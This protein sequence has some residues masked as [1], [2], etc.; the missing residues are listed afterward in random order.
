MNL[1]RRPASHRTSAHRLSAPL[2]VLVLA[3]A[4]PVAAAADDGTPG[5]G[6]KDL[7]PDP[8]AV[9]PPLLQKPIYGCADSVVVKGFAPHAGLR[10][11]VAG[12]MNPI[13]QK[14]GVHTDGEPV[15]V[16]ISFTAGQV[17]TATQI[18]GGVESPHS[19]A[20]TVKNY[21][22]DY[23]SG[24]P[25]PRIDPATCLDCGKAVGVNDVIP[26][27]WWKVYAE[28]PKQGGGFDPPVQIGG[29]QDFPY[30]FVPGF[31]TGQ[32]ITVRS[33]IC[34]DT[35]PLSDPQI[36][37]ADPGSIPAPVIDTVYEGADRVVVRGPGGTALLDGA[38]LTVYGNLVPPPGDV[39]GGQAT[40]GGAQQVLITPNAPAG[41]HKY[42][43]AQAL[44]SSS[45]PGP[46]TPEQPC[47]K[48]P[49]ATI[50]SPL[51]GDT[52]VEVT[53]FVPGSVIRIYDGIKQIGL[54][55]GPEI[56][57]LQPI[58]NGDKIT[59]VQS[60]GACQGDATYVAQAG[61]GDR[62]P[63]ACSA[64]WPTFRHS[65][66]RDG[67]QP[68]ASAIADPDKVRH[69]KVKWK[70]SPPPVDGPVAFRAS[71]IIYMGRV[72]V[73]NGNGR[74]YALD[75][76]TGNPLWTY[77][78]PPA[79]ALTSTYV[80]NPSSRGLAA[81]AAIGVAKE[82]TVVIFGAPDRSIGL[83]LGS[84]RLFAVDLNGNGVWQSPEI[85]VLNGTTSGSTSE[86]HEQLGYSS[87]LV[88][89]NRIYIGMADHGDSPIQKG[90]VAVVDA[91][92]GSILNP[93]FFIATGT[94]GGGVWSSV[95]GGLDKNVVALTTGNSNDGQPEPSPDHALSM[96]GLDAGNGGINWKLRAVPYALDGDP[97][98]AAGPALLDTRCGHV[99]ASTQ[100]DGWSYAARSDSTGGGLPTVR[101]QFPPTGIPFTSGDHGD[102]RYI[103]PGAGWN[104]TYI[105]T[106]GGFELE[107]GHPGFGFRR[108]HA[109]DACAPPNQPVR[110]IS[111]NLPTTIACPDEA[112]PDF[113]Q[114]CEYQLGPSTV[115]RGIVFVGTAAGHLVVLADPAAYAH[116]G[117]VCVNT[118][119]PNGI[120]AAN[121][122]ALVPKPMMLADVDLGAGAIQTEP[123]LADGH[124]FV[125]TDGGTVFMLDPGK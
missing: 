85:A 96:L 44:C 91:D 109:L 74:L 79:Q 29:N 46:T 75:A 18:V 122:L 1:L 113:D 100:K 51:P 21:K 62:D 54:G 102:T 103:K 106:D 80:E 16:S 107:A 57:L 59:V 52:V 88:L 3:L 56:A 53:D 70:W 14:V 68:F 49:P 90:R 115:S 108:L 35:S 23:P 124:V 32:R 120:C 83:K 60:L 15:H 24:L 4:F 86:R 45:G 93:S 2:A 34:A 42:S 72:Y 73:G 116:A 77:P 99:A 33:G 36:V 58:Q 19:N 40:P 97:D 37:K 95:A 38:A 47:S 28:D 84:G 8:K 119:V 110:W 92:N 7:K 5:H 121:G 76:A 61:C 67:Q 71:P 123:A 12:T 10:V 63:N 41:N 69:L 39:V 105:T 81:S 98:W 65:G 27:A 13:G 50:R 118:E 6:G 82:Q 111:D 26:G 112:H 11:Y 30:T 31:K 20:V 17:V 117:S 89:G 114:A 55:G 94:R 22:D 64:D 25:Q 48:L 104:D 9:S 78:K 87:P 43:A 66:L 125:A 101:W